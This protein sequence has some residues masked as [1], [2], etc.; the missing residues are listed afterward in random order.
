MLTGKQRSTLKKM[1]NTL[2]STAQIGKSGLTEA[3]INDITLQLENKE[4]IKINVLN[5]SPVDAKEI[6]DEVLEKTGAEFVQQL[7]NKLVIYKESEENKHI[8]LD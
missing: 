3:I 5:N 8:E 6:V 7:G 4:L 1:A 2:N